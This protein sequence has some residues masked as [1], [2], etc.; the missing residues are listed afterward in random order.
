MKIGII[1]SQYWPHAGGIE[2]HIEQLTD[3]L[4][5]RGHIVTV[6][7]AD[8]KSQLSDMTVHDEVLVR[9]LAPVG[10]DSAFH[11]A[12]GIWSLI[13]RTSFD[14]IHVHNYHSLPFTIGGIGSKVPLV[15]TPHYH[16]ESDDPFRNKMLKLYNPIGRKVLNSAAAVIAVSTWEQERLKRDFGTDSIIIPNGIEIDRFASASPDSNK[17]PILLTVG[18]LVEYK[19]IQHVIRALTELPDYTLRIAG[20]GPYRDT[21]EQDAIEAGVDNRVKFLGYVPDSKL[22]KQYAAADV[23]VSMSSIE[24]AGITVGESLAAGTPAVVRPSKGLTDWTTRSDCI[25]SKPTEIP[26]KVH[27]AV[28][29]SSPSESLPTWEQTIDRVESIYKQIQ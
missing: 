9:R 10:P 21:L 24:A 1:T 5:D 18:R 14:I 12:P 6:I 27:K 22:P 19:G 7:S 25:R 3:G 29:Q 17:N 13:R 23:F 4:T 15:C 28:S 11:F 26:E 16:A 2:K 20:D 8:A